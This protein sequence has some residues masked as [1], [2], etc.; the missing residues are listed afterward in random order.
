MATSNDLYGILGVARNATSAQIRKAYHSKARK[1]H[2]DKFPGDETKTAQFQELK[3]AYEE[4]SDKGRREKYDDTGLTEEVAAENPQAAYHASVALE[5]IRPE[6]INITEA[7]YLN[8]V[9]KTLNI[10]GK[11]VTFNIPARHKGDLNISK[12]E[13]DPSLA[14]QCSS[15]IINVIPPF[16]EPKAG[17][18]VKVFIN[19]NG[20]NAN[21]K[22][23]HRDR[24]EVKGFVLNF[25]KPTSTSYK[26]FMILDEASIQEVPSLSSQNFI[27]MVRVDEAFMGN[28]E[29][30][31]TT[32][33]ERFRESFNEKTFVDA[34]GE[35]KKFH[36]VK[37][38]NMLK[39]AGK[40]MF[41]VTPI[42]LRRP[43]ER[44]HSFNLKITGK[45]GKGEV[46][47]EITEGTLVED[48]I[49]T[50]TLANGGGAA[51]AAPAAAA[52]AA[53]A[54]EP[55]PEPVPAEEE[56]AMV[57]AEEAARVAAA[58]AAAQAEAEAAQAEAEAAQ[59]A[60]EE[61]AQAAEEEAARLAAEEE[62][63]RVAEEEA[64]RLAAEEA[65]T[66]IQSGSRGMRGRRIA[67]ILADRQKAISDRQKAIVA[68]EQALADAQSA[69]H[70]A[71]SAYHE[72]P[73]YGGGRKRRSKRKS[74]K[75]NN[76][77]SKRKK[78]INKSKRRKNTK[79]R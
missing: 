76:K 41:Q 32:E 28:F 60:E 57:A 56:S 53:A 19:K 15:V 33:I 47:T 35:S 70:D 63:A 78:R 31:D 38:Y 46:S 20:R 48:F 69:Y 36:S 10:R 67:N 1:C 64:A 79:R 9:T 51:A 77:Y 43:T 42:H 8:G 55:E 72:A 40:D 58:Q 29:L 18:F 66:I 75:R 30:L 71:R 2:P 54:A 39:E 50:I 24:V 34:L 16:T 59:A 21:I 73:T 26:Y 68:A 27:M 25:V 6:P 5:P 4:L 37:F 13:L 61:A 49:D 45:D 52:P 44:F 7:E 62:A 65:A 23:G 22:A 11:D 14:R 12:S 74:K 17:N 3:K